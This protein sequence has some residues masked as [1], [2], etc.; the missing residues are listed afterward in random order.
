M[1]KPW[2]ALVSSGSRYSAIFLQIAEVGITEID[3][4]SADYENRTKSAN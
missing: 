2:S 3:S 4:K 1:E